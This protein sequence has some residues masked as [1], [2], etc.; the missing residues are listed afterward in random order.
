ME[1]VGTAAPP[2]PA[3]AASSPAASSSPA[4]AAAAVGGAGGASAV[5]GHERGRIEVQVGGRKRKNGKIPTDLKDWEALRAEVVGQLKRAEEK[6]QREEAEAAE[7]GMEGAYQAAGG[8]CGLE[9]E[10]LGFKVSVVGGVRIVEV[11][12][13]QAEELM[14]GVCGGRG[15]NYGVVMEEGEDKE[16]EEGDEEWG[17]EKEG[18]EE[19][20]VDD[21]AKVVT[22][23]NMD[24]RG[25]SGNN[26]GMVEE[27]GEVEAG[28]E[29]A[30]EEDEREAEEELSHEG[31]PSVKEIEIQRLARNGRK[32]GVDVEEGED[33]R[34]EDENGEEGGQEQKGEEE[35]RGK[36]REEGGPVVGMDTDATDG[37]NS[38]CERMVV[39]CD[40]GIDRTIEDGMIHV[41]TTEE[42]GSKEDCDMVGENGIDCVADDGII[43]REETEGGGS[44]AIAGRGQSSGKLLEI[45][46]AA[47]ASSGESPTHEMG[48]QEGIGWEAK[49]GLLHQNA[50]GEGGN[51]AR[52]FCGQEAG[53]VGNPPSASQ[54]PQVGLSADGGVQRAAHGCAGPQI[55][56]S[57]VASCSAARDV[58]RAQIA[59]RDDDRDIHKDV[60]GNIERARI[61]DGQAAQ[62]STQEIGEHAR[63][64]EEGGVVMIVEEVDDDDDSIGIDKE[65]VD[66]D[67]EVDVEDEEEQLEKGREYRVGPDTGG[68]IDASMRSRNALPRHSKGGRR[69]G[70]VR[71]KRAEER[72]RRGVIENS[73]GVVTTASDPPCTGVG[74]GKGRD[75][76]GAGEGEGKEEGGV[77]VKDSVCWEDVLAADT[78]KV[79]DVIKERGMNYMLAGRIQVRQ[80]CGHCL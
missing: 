35:G 68:R 5:S 15:E 38:E 40:D 6:R 69:G 7:W 77:D 26:T 37:E 46:A 59:D 64:K 27:E 12:E 63:D 70:G 4:A 14:R 45:L 8:D 33:E 50:A 44:K 57:C 55:H 29:K 17:R 75:G 10:G 11:S 56:Q 60:D 39:W 74:A 66:K 41:A 49:D 71:Q 22:D 20:L 23:L 43:H 2:A 24:A 28:E 65:E 53:K 32:S 73:M 19:D 3:P 34:D 47:S 78:D 31:A 36:G 21:G 61:S 25:V 62:E 48:E 1:A 13:E 42:E 30:Q 58:E 76:E 9:F 79:A 72:R 52:T 51:E 54:P 16:G 67:S 80:D 18:R